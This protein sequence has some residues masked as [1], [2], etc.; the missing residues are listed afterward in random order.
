MSS[1]PATPPLQPSNPERR[2]GETLVQLAAAAAK[3]DRQAF[4]AIH[5]RLSGGLYRLFMDR[6]N[7]RVEVVEDLCQRTWLAV[8]ESLQAGRY[9]PSRSAM[10]TFVYAVGYKLW[11]QQLRTFARPETLVPDVADRSD[12]SDGDPQDAAGLAEL[13]QNVRE[14]LKASGPE[15]LLTEEER[16]I[17]RASAAGASD[18][19]LARQLNIAASTLNARKQSAFQ[20]IRRYLAKKGHRVDSIER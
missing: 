5:R 20:K 2:E 18:R 14:C 10:T 13:L 12:V 15:P 3:G 11:L 8:W 17:V 9:D 6:T 7:G 4:E 16:G 1:P 19:D